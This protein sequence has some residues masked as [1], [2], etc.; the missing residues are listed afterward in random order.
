MTLSAS[1]QRCRGQ[2]FPPW[3]PA[4]PK[5]RRIHGVATLV[6]PLRSHKCSQRSCPDRTL[7][8]YRFRRGFYKNGV[9]GGAPAWKT[10]D[11]LSIFITSDPHY[12]VCIK[13]ITCNKITPTWPREKYDLEAKMDA[14]QRC[15]A[16]EMFN[17]RTIPCIVSGSWIWK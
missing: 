15:E 8:S 17:R 13:E 11:I 1:L 12:D 5:K 10:I 14:F 2:G 6:T 16:I 7:I 9:S 3:L 4:E